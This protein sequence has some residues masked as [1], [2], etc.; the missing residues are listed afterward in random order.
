MPSLRIFAGPNGSGKS[1]IIK[2]VKK[3]T[4]NGKLLNLGFYINADDIVVELKKNS[5][6]F[7]DYGVI[8][9][10]TFFI[11]FAEQSGLL[12]KHFTKTALLKSFIENQGCLRLTNKDFVEKL[13]QLIARFLREQMLLSKKHFSFETVF[14]HPSNIDIIKDATKKGF[15]VYLYFIATESPEINIYRV[16]NRVKLKGHNVP[17][18]KIISR[19]YRSLEL[20][21]TAAQNCNQVFFFD[22]SGETYKQVAHLKNNAIKQL[23]PNDELPA[24]FRKYYMNKLPK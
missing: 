2:M 16:Q 23:L 17:E 18:D 3:F 15:S 13:A 9:Q 10:K 12:D 24:W 20:M 4:R 5:F 22:N 6:S 1:T 11:H 19:Y 7:S 21:Y 14:S 8:F